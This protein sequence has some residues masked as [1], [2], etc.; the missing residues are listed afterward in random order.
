[1][2]HDIL[3]SVADPALLHF[4]TSSHKRCNFRKTVTDHNMCVM[5]FPTHF[6]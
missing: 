1:M 6:V 4:F 2:A 5:S 3:S